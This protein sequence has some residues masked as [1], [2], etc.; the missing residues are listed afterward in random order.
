M[1][2]NPIILVFTV[3]ALR[4][5]L[6]GYHRYDRDTSPFLGSLADQIACFTSAISAC[7]QTR[8]DPSIVHRSTPICSRPTVTYEIDERMEALGYNDRRN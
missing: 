8:G 4:V 5:D 2:E 3:D 7:P 6:L 1:T